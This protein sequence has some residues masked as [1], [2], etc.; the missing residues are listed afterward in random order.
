MRRCFS[1]LYGVSL[2]GTYMPGLRV[3]GEALPQ[4]RMARATSFYTSSFGSELRSL[5]WRQRSLREWS[6]GTG[7]MWWRRCVPAWRQ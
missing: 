4:E 6:T 5:I 1:G 2:A 7:S 3:M